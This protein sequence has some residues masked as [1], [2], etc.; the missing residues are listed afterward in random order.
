MEIKELLDKIVVVC[1]AKAQEVN[2]END[3]NPEKVVL[4]D[5]VMNTIEEFKQEFKGW[6]VRE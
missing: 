1:I 6:E 2:F 4:L 5:D 3:T